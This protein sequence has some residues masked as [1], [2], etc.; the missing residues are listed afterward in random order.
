M[1]N[2][3]HKK[4]RE[5]LISVHSNFCS[6]CRYC[7]L[8]CSFVRTGTCNLAESRIRLHRIDGKERYS[9]SFTSDCDQCGYCIRFCFYGVLREVGTVPQKPLS[10]PL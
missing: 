3:R 7:Q 1:I 8:A 5:K 4:P 6:E 9:I 10:Q 2:Q